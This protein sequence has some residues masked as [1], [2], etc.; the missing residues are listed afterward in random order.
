MN[1]V[2]LRMHVYGAMGDNYP[3]T[4][5]MLDL[6]EQLGIKAE[7]TPLGGSVYLIRLPNRPDMVGTVVDIDADYSKEKDQGKS[8]Q[9]I[10]W[11]KNKAILCDEGK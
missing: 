7:L 8:C 2:F 9:I 11:V 10:R 5:G 6:L 3:R 4:R 1:D